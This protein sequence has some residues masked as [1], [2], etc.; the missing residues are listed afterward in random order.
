MGESVTLPAK[1]GES[2]IVF[3]GRRFVSDDDIRMTRYFYAITYFGATA[4]F[5]TLL[6]LKLN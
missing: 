2:V 4:L 3:S 6:L 1:I 5:S